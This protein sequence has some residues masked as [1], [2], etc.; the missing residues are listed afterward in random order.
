MSFDIS[1]IK[2]GN[3]NDE[4]YFNPETNSYMTIS[5]QLKIQELEKQLNEK[6]K[7]ERKKLDN[8]ISYFYKR[9]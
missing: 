3:Y 9:N 5:Q 4:I 8:I 6:K 7:D 2:M 1:K